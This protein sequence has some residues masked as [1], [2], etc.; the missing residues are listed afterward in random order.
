MTPKRGWGGGDWREIFFRDGKKFPPKKLIFWEGKI[1]LPKKLI[2][3][4][5]RGGEKKFP[6][7]KIPRNFFLKRIFT[8]PL[9]S[10]LEIL[11]LSERDI[12]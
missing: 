5:G 8:H 10:V 11:R 9:A 6:R 2:F 4:R 7:K 12:N 1:F 3:D